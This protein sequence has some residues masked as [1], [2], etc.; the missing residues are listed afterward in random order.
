MKKN[1]IVIDFDETLIPFDSFRK[2]VFLWLK[3]YPLTLLLLIACRKLR[4]LSAADLKN[5]VVKKAKTNKKFNEIN[6]HFVQYLYL[7]IDKKLLTKIESEKNNEETIMLLL[8]AS[9]HEYINQV[10]AALGFT[11]QGSYADSNNEYQ[12]FHGIQKTEFIKKNYPQDKYI[13]QYAIS[14]SKSDLEMISMFLKHDLIGL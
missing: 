4:L 7:N 14:D 2:F 13:Y 9:P 12:H 6:N 10:G 5:R 3:Y 8:S 1:L 11:A